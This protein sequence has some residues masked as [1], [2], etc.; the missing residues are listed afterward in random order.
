MSGGVSV[1]LGEGVRAISALIFAQQGKFADAI[2]CAERSP[3]A[4]GIDQDSSEDDA[5]ALAVFIAQWASGS[6]ATARRN[7]AAGQDYPPSK[8]QIPNAVEASLAALALGEGQWTEAAQRAERALE[9]TAPDDPLGVNALLRGVLACAQAASGAR[10]EARSTILKAQV[11]REGPTRTLKGM[12]EV[13]LLEARMWNNEPSLRS[14]ALKLIAWAEAENFPYVQLRAR[15]VLA[16]AEGRVRAADLDRARS[17]AVHIDDPIRSVIV[18]YFEELNLGNSHWDSVATRLLSDFGIWVPLPR[19]PLLSAREREIAL[20]AALGYS[21]RW[22]AEHFV[23]SCRTVET[24]LR[25]VFTKLGVSG[26]DALRLQLRRGQLS[27][28]FP[29]DRC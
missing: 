13:F 9:R 11:A 20:H 6:L 28:I 10:L 2:A 24:H 4:V 7:L 21:N 18:N 16:A 23:L 22:I 14:D 17:L 27:V 3:E 29:R 1:A 19:V 15:L 25:H 26:R 5:L 8:S 12:A